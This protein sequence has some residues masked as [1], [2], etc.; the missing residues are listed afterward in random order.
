M[1]VYGYSERR[2]INSLMYSMNPDQMSKFITLLTGDKLLPGDHDS[3]DILIEQSLSDFGDADLIIMYT[4]SN[5]RVAAFIEAKVKTW[6]TKKWTISS[7]YRK[8]NDTSYKY[9]G[10]NIFRQLSL[11]KA[12]VENFDSAK[13]GITISDSRVCGKKKTKKTGDNSVVQE[14][15]NKIRE[16]D[17]FVYIGIVPDS[18][19][20]INQLKPEDSESCIKFIPWSTIFNFSEHEKLKNALLN[21]DYNSG[22]I[23]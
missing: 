9:N 18:P 16:A 5:K 8:F 7:E 15:L 19:E 2:M 6:S 14:A 22:Q 3:I 4:T 20:N 21:F 1:T 17:H 23:Y 12:L 10:S 13:S 11:K